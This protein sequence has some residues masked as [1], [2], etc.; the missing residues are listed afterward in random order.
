ML[1]N[2]RSE[3]DP[4]SGDERRRETSDLVDV[5]RR[6]KPRQRRAAE[7]RVLRY[8]VLFKTGIPAADLE[9]WLGANCR[10]DWSM[11]LEDMDDGLRS[12]TLRIMFET[13]SDRD[14]FKASARSIR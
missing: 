8:T 6:S 14:R 1:L 13:P 2:R 4:R 5:E 12:K 10:G 3:K 11:V 7:R 9:N